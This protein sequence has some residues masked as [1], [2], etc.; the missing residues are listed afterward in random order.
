VKR[1]E[2][3]WYRFGSPDKRRP[4]VILTRDSVIEYLSEV[5]VAPITSKIRDIPSE[6][7]VSKGEGLPR[8]CAVNC[9]HIQTVAKARIGKRIAQLS[10]TRLEELRTAVS[11]ALGL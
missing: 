8:A 9:D 5:T 10:G 6:V 2:I 3:C 7:V 11:F 1:G 4:V